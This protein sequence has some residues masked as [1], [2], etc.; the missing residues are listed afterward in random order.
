MRPELLRH[1][2]AHDPHLWDNLASRTVCSA[3]LLENTRFHIRQT[4]IFAPKGM[5]YA[6]HRDLRGHSYLEFLPEWRMC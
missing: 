1:I 6:V 3:Q 2:G 5:W 4:V